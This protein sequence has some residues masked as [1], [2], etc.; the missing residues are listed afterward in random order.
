MILSEETLASWAKGPGATEQVKCDNA[1]AA[2]RKA[3]AKHE[4]LSQMD[5]C[6]FH[7]G[8][9]RNKTNVRLDSDVD[10]CV[11][12]NTTFFP[13]YPDGTS[14][15]TYGNEPGSIT[16]TEYKGCVQRALEDYFGKS[17]VTRGNKAFNI[18]ANSYRVNADVVATFEHRRYSRDG[19]YLSGIGFDTDRG[20]RIYNWPEQHYE[21]GLAKHKNTGRRYRKIVRILKKLRNKM[22]EEGVIAAKGIASCLIESLVWNCA[23]SAFEHDTYSRDVREV[24]ASIFNDTMKEDTCSEWGEVSELKY[25]FR[26][27]QPWTRPQAHAFVS[28]AWDYLELE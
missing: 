25:L 15:E 20:V 7:Q 12:L 18:H 10:I 1:E 4:Q 16:F 2:I 11:R 22:Q 14:H 27:N 19:N 17:S 9:Y 23:R 13:Y 28:A 24:L 8:S 5:V 21:N 6:V 3:L 26:P